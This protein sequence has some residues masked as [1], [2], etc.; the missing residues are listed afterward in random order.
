MKVIVI[1]VAIV[2][3]TTTMINITSIVQLLFYM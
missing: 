1:I 2:P 3:M